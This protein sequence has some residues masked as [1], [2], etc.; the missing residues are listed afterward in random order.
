MRS[1]I[2]IS[3]IVCIVCGG[4]VAA[5]NTR[6]APRAAASSSYT[7]AATVAGAA[8]RITLSAQQAAAVRPYLES[9]TGHGRHG[10]LPPGIARNLARGKSLP[11]G[12]AKAYLPPPIVAQ[13][14]R[15][16][17]GLDYVVVAGKLLL[18]E[19]ATAAIHDVLME[20]AFGR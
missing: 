13:L 8:V 5:G 14:P 15:L 16:P 3:A 6:P 4:C 19:A 1:R 18:V 12:I 17:S 7:A 10:A 2:L 9:S 20:V 11:P